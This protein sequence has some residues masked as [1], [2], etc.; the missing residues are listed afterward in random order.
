MKTLSSPAIPLVKTLPPCGAGL[1][2]VIPSSEFVLDVFSTP[3]M[4]VST[5]LIDTNG[6]RLIFRTIFTHVDFQEATLAQVGPFGR[7][8][9]ASRGTRQLALGF[10]TGEWQIRVTS[11]LLLEMSLDDLL[12]KKDGM[13]AMVTIPL[14]LPDG[15]KFV[16]S[17]ASRPV[18]PAT[19]GCKSCPRFARISRTEVAGKTATLFL[20]GGFV[21][22]YGKLPSLQD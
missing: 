10:E 4:G 5:C 14:I 7:V 8:S 9:S 16:L 12:R 15:S 11:E 19:D 1:Q 2:S 13:G 22:L 18:T 20:A 17:A 6:A 3:N 21:K